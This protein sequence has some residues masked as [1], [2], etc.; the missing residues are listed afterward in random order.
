MGCKVSSCVHHLVSSN[1][2]SR[3]CTKTRAAS[4]CQSEFAGGGAGPG[5]R[6]ELLMRA[7]ALTR[8]PWVL[9][10]FCLLVPPA[11]D[12]AGGPDSSAG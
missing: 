2:G 4:V 8:D 3:K 6:A 1:A 5:I 11:A 12:S 9:N 10:S 7:P